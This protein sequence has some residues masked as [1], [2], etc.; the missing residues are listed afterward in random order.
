[1]DPNFANAHFKLALVYEIKGMYRE[2]V[3]EY[4]KNETISGTNTEAVERL[5]EAYATLG[6]DYAAPDPASR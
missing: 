2:A 5:R 6:W 1:M 4:V 3:E